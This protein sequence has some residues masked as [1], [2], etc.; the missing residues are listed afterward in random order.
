[1][2]TQRVGIDGLAL[3]WFSSYLTSRTQA[4][5]H[6]DQQ[7][8]LFA[9][10]CSVP[11]GSVLGPVEF[12][13][14]I[15]ELAALIDGFHLSHHLYADDAQ[16]IS[17]TRIDEI[18]FTIER[19]Q[20]CIESIHTWCS[21]RRLQ[22]NSSKTEVIWFGTK[23]SLE[24]IDSIDL[25]LHIGN[26]VIVPATSVRDLGV[27]LDRELSMRRHINKVASICYFHLRRLKTVRR[28]LGEKT[29]T[30]LVT[31]FVTS[32]LDYCNSVLAGLPK[33]SIM[34]LQR[35]QNAAARLIHALPSNCVS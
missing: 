24:K 9:V 8:Q 22:L 10:N 35:V 29:T 1:V 16:L 17:R 34:P 7:S 14:Y 25:S 2:L 5:H 32:R 3:A 19:M 4:Y 27:I 26:D 28:T 11:Q 33:S 23:S 21:S 13:V 18:G 12:I 6:D 15:E 20:L 31:A 30:S